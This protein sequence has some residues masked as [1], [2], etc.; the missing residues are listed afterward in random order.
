MKLK[1]TWLR[2]FGHHHELRR[3]VGADPRE[4]RALHREQQVPLRQR[5]R[6]AGGR[7]GPA[8]VQDPGR[9][10]QQRC[11][12]GVRGREVQGS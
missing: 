5:H 8:E 3:G 2:P 9:M 6:G 4:G 7:G 1:R 12:E 10:L 11:G